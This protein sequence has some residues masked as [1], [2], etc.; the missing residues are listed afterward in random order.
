MKKEVIVAILIGA[1]L[2][3]GLA[4]M[5]QWKS[6]KGKLTPSSPA[7]KNEVSAKPTRSPEKATPTPVSSVKLTISEPENEAVVNKSSIVIKGHT[8]PGATVVL[9][10][11]EDEVILEAS[12]SGS[13]RTDFELTGGVNDIEA[14]A[15]DDKGNEAKEILTVTYS[16]AKF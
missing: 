11:N 3:L 1:I 12:Q 8:I 14:T 16:T 4:G 10:G 9:I 5:K 2:G 15:Y 7:V 13:F 6:L